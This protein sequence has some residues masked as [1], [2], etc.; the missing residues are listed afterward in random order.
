MTH[1]RLDIISRLARGGA[2][3]VT[4][5]ARAEGV[6]PQ[7]MDS[8]IQILE[9]ADLIVREPDTSDRRRYVLCLTPQTHE[10]HGT[11]DRLHQAVHS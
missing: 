10:L 6:R 1:I 8:N 11:Y 7:S 5:F 9:D 4:D 2:G 3:S